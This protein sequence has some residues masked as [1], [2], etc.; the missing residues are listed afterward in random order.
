MKPTSH[1]KYCGEKIGESEYF[2]R[3]P[4][5]DDACLNYHKE[6]NE[7]VLHQGEMGHHSV[8][9]SYCPWCGRKLRP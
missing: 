6:T 9:V 5:K 2:V 3:F 4:G 7:W 1:C 8:S